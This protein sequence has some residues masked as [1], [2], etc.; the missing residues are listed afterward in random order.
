MSAPDRPSTSF[1]RKM[2]EALVC[3]VTQG[4]LIYDERHS[5]LSQNRLALPFSCATASRSCFPLKPSNFS[6][7]SLPCH[8]FG[9]IPCKARGLP[10]KALAQLGHGI[11][12]TQAQISRSAQ[13]YTIV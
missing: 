2:L 5:V 4:T 12:Q 7:K 3:P 1:D 6:L 9:Q 8:Q 11:Y 13:N 10:H